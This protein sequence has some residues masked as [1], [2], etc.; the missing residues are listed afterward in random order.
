MLPTTKKP[1][2]SLK[3]APEL[4]HLKEEGHAPVGQAVAGIGGSAHILRVAAGLG[5]MAMWLQA[6]SEAILHPAG[7]FGLS[8]LLRPGHAMVAVVVAV[9]VEVQAGRVQFHP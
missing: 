3:S 4:L 6:P 9:P 2:P 7:S 8:L 1:Q 5:C